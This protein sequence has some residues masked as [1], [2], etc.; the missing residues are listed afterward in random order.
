ML[1]LGSLVR[2]FKHFGATLFFYVLFL[3]FSFMVLLVQLPVAKHVY[4]FVFVTVHIY[5][6]A[7]SYIH[8]T[9]KV[10]C[11]RLQHIKYS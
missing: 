10:T 9:D 8:I 6:F 1:K 7:P 5:A 3:L 4:I 11:H 2:I